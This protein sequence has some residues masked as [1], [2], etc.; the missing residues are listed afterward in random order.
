MINSTW[1][2]I[3]LL[4]VV[5]YGY[6][7][8]VSL[9]LYLVPLAIVVALLAIYFLMDKS[10]RNFAF[11]SEAFEKKIHKLS[12]ENKNLAD[13]LAELKKMLE[14]NNTQKEKLDHEKQSMI[15]KIKEL[16][17]QIEKLT[18]VEIAEKEDI[19]VEYYLKGKL[20]E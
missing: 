5:C 15:L 3:Q 11:K 18:K 7:L 9:Y 13:E 17:K 12:T 4:P 1:C 2:F 10:K 14:E 8:S 19:I 16:E 6:I 20:D